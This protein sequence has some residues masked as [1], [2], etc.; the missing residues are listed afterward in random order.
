VRVCFISRE[1]PPDTG[2]GG[3]A[4]FTRN[5]AHGVANLGHEV[6]VVSFT[7]DKPKIESD[8]SIKIHRIRPVLEDCEVSLP[9]ILMPHS[10]SAL[11]NSGALWKTF[12]DLHLNKPFDVVDA[13]EL[14]A[15]G[16]FPAITKV[17][18]LVVRLYTPHSKFIAEGFHNI[19]STF[20]NELVAVLERI[21]ILNADI[22][23]SPSLNLAKFVAEDIKRP[24]ETFQIVQNPIDTN[25]FHPEG[26]KS[27]T[28]PNE[29]K[30]L[31]V[32]RLEERKG[33]HYLIQAIPE[34]IK[35][36]PNA[37]FY[38]IGAD[39]N[40]AK[41]NNSVKAELLEIINRNG[42]KTNTTFIP[43]VALT[44]LPGYYRGA[45]VCVVPSIYDNS[46]YTCLEAMSC[47]AAVV[48]TTSGGIPEYLIHG[49]SGLL[50]PP[51]DS[52]ALADAIVR[53]LSNDEERQALGANARLRVE[54]CFSSNLI[55]EQMIVLYDIARAR[56]N[57][58]PS[59]GYDRN[60]ESI[61]SELERLMRLCQSSLYDLLYARSLEFRIKHWFDLAKAEPLLLL[62]KAF[63][64]FCKQPVAR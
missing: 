15:E 24:V 42:T 60:M 11:R 55:A 63:Q 56:F 4:T 64:R 18:P 6:E 21:A 58:Q 28:N 1:Y 32:G 50:V 52:R 44:E 10:T 54:T 31:F 57:G 17:A 8:G 47:G 51:R 46:P 29:K 2:W 13:P 22:V 20:D 7:R 19:Q 40:T 16:L 36:E 39:T 59:R 38:I 23:T 14:L 34:V 41:C 3:I 45:D 27:L 26:S 33:I 43:R 53:V 12:L 35:S 48:G 37:H 9:N 49:E 30:V 5:L 61:A 62:K 25:E